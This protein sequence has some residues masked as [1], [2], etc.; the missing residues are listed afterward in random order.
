MY[1]QLT[2]KMGESIRIDSI[3]FKPGY[4]YC[5]TIADPYE[6]DFYYD[7]LQDALLKDTIIK[8]DKIRY[9]GNCL[10]PVFNENDFS[11]VEPIQNYIPISVRPVK[12]ANQVV[13]CF[14][15]P[16][17]DVCGGSYIDIKKDVNRKKKKI[18]L[19]MKEVLIR[20][21]FLYGKSPEGKMPE[22]ILSRV[23]LEAL[24]LGTY[25]LIIRIN[26]EDEHYQLKV[27]QDNVSLE[28]TK[29]HQFLKLY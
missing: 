23:I 6:E 18:S 21:D 24:E 4:K 2:G 5:K 1:I 16:I 7:L 26:N 15:L 13:L 20:K 10:N 8:R 3:V 12:S 29:Q 11:V 19:E 9:V 22:L 27:Q 25:D 17:K 28:I 14:L